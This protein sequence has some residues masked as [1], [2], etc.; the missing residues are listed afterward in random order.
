M[1]NPQIPQIQLIDCSKVH[2]SPHNKCNGDRAEVGELVE[3]IKA[4]GLLQEPIVRPHPSI[5]GEFELV[6]GERRW[7][8]CKEIWQEL[9]CK[10]MNLT[11]KEA[12]AATV[13]ENMH[14]QGLSPLEEV[15]QI[16]V[17]FDLGLSSEDVAAKLGK[18]TKWVSRRCKLLNL[19]DKVLAAYKKQPND[20]ENESDD[21]DGIPDLS[22]W[23]VTHL[24]L[25]S[26]FD[27]KVQD[28]FI[29]KNGY[30]IEDI[31]S[32]ELRRRLNNTLCELKNVKWDIYDAF[33]VPEAGACST[34]QKR[35]GV[36]VELF[37]ELD[38][39]DRCTDS[40]CFD[41]KQET[42]LKNIEDNLRSKNPELVMYD[43]DR[44]YGVVECKKSDPGAQLALITDG[45]DVGK[46]VY[47]KEKNPSKTKPK[48][49]IVED[50]QQRISA[51]RTEYVIDKILAKL[52]KESNEPNLILSLTENEVL[53]IAIIFG[54]R[55]Y[56][57]AVDDR[58]IDSTKTVFEQYDQY[59]KIRSESLSDL[60]IYDL[61]KC[62]IP[63]IVEILNYKKRTGSQDISE[64]SKV[65]QLFHIDFS[66]LVNN[67]LSEYKMPDE[68]KPSKTKRS[69]K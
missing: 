18:D 36:Q 30:W 39:N 4:Q 64:V 38:E 21:D 34:C 53:R 7:R 37:S 54:C 23:T 2:P 31:T 3:T 58:S 28:D 32:I 61:A 8:A 14:R 22:K 12:H 65:A 27:K 52:N 59:S 69:K 42:W 44:S 15:E 5:E 40:K 29:D 50:V 19:S 13:I 43:P 57:M 66:E 62:T 41:L 55:R 20:S 17:L 47:V 25:I 1:L 49:E 48:E 51:K 60:L 67:S 9:P 35:T 63:G 45:E 26:R 24:E 6:V 33:V 68:K 16:Q 10:V 11:D 46:T 56:D